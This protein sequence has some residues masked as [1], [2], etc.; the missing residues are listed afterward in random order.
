MSGGR[1]VITEER[2]ITGIAAAVPKM[3]RKQ[4]MV[5]MLSRPVNKEDN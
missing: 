3:Y 5:F 2:I 4:S 1:E